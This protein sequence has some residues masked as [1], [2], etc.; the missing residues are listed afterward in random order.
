MYR[1]S[2]PLTLLL[3]SHGV[4]AQSE[5]APEAPAELPASSPK[6]RFIDKPFAVESRIGFG[7]SVGLLGV[8]AEID[9]LDFV[10]LGGGVGLNPWGPVW[11]AHVR[12]RPLILDFR[13]KT[14]FAVIL[15]GAF[16]RGR[17]GDVGIGGVLDSLCEGNPSDPESNCYDPL[18]VPKAT[19]W[20]QLEAGAELRLQFGL[21]LRMSW[22]VGRALTSLT[23]RCTAEGIAAPCAKNSEPDRWIAVDTLAVGYAF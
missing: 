15:E 12:V 23:P 20:A 2:L 11:G 1:F 14:L 18:V 17:Y 4:L 7:T 8:A 16:S 5:V 10:A 22:G 3:V 13:R 9:P 6:A 19:S 21:T